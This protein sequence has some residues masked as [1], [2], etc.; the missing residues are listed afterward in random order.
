MDLIYCPFGKN[1]KNCEIINDFE[2]VDSENRVFPVKRYKLSE[3]RFKVYNMA[4][5]KEVKNYSTITDLSLKVNLGATQGN[6]V[7]GIK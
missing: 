5:L 4:K 6:L 3:C 1:C 7:K 2:L